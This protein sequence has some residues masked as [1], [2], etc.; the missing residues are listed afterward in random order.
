MNNFSY[1]KNTHTHT[2]TPHTQTHYT[3]TSK[4][5]SVVRTLD[6][7]NDLTFLRI[8]SKKH[9]IMISPDKE[10]MLIVIQRSDGAASASASSK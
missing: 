7:T 10:H 5:R 2:H 6:N 1:Y 4:A 3:Q 9:E 8:R